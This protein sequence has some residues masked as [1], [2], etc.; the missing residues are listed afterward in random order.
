MYNVKFDFSFNGQD[1][2]RYECLST[3]GNPF[4][5]MLKV[6]GQ[7]VDSVEFVSIDKVEG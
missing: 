7:I 1:V 2:K 6:L 5:A 3:A 4:E